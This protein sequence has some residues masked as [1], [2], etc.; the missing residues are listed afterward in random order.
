M[1]FIFKGNKGFSLVELMIVVGIIGILST[2]AM[3][4]MQT[5]MA[6]AKQSEVKVNLGHMYTLELAYYGDTGSY[7]DMAAIG[8]VKP[9]NAKYT[10]SVP[11][12][13]ASFSAQGT[14][15]ADGLCKGSSTDTWTID[16]TQ[17]L[18][19]T[20]KFTKCD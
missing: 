18:S 8:Y 6:K 3:P 20:A 4:R 12:S 17:T 1:K 5:F 2:M 9:A 10:Y 19:N 7:G 11:S 14:I 16:Q 13:G 15:A